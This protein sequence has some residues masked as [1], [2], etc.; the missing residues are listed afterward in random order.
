MGLALLLI[1]AAGCGR[2]GPTLLPV[3]GVV[4][5]DGRPVAQ[6]GIIFSPAEGG[7]AASGSTDAQGKFQLRTVNESGA[8]AGKHLVTVTKQETT[9]LGD[10]GAVGPEGIKAIWHV[11]EKYSN[12]KTSGLECTVGSDSDDVQIE[13]SSQ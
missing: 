13:L 5:L 11:P 2:R 12:R 6:A 8:V 4:T 3:S 9:G 1:V 10:F 7:P